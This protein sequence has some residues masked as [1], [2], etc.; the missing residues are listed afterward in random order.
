MAAPPDKH[1][2][3]NIKTT[4]GSWSERF[5][6]NNKVRVLLERAIE[7]FGL[8][9]NPPLPYKV[10]RESS[11]ETLAL[12]QRLGDYELADGETILIQATRPT[13]G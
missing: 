5:Q 1:L 10:I 4:A 8:D 3:L 2:T 6:P 7:H 11:G 12:D 9:P 13:D